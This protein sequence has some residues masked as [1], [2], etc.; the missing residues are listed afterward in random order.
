MSNLSN[1][2]FLQIN[3]H[4]SNRRRLLKKLLADLFAFDL[5]GI[6]LYTNDKIVICV[7]SDCPALISLTNRNCTECFH[8]K[9][10]RVNF[11]I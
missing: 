6:H 2:I 10:I 11:G 5:F 3:L 4:S 7:L 9:L 8:N 1:L